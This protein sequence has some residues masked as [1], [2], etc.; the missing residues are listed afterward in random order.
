MALDEK[1]IT[2]AILDRYFQK[3]KENLSV[4]VAV[5]GGGPSGL[6]CSYFL[7]KNGFGNPFR[8]ETLHRRRNVGRGDDVQ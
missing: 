8:K 3:L 4:D 2:Q 6:V 5:V 7:V 1:I